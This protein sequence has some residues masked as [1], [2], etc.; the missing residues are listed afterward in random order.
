MLS[1][2]EVAPVNRAVIDDALKLGFK[3]FEDGVMHEA[4][5]HVGAEAIVTRNAKDFKKGS[6]SVYEPI[7]L[8]RL[9]RAEQGK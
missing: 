5:Q 6:P 4:G 3:D 1:R 2:F 8:V 9:L 7:D